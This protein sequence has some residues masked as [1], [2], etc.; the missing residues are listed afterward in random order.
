[1]RLMRKRPW[2]QVT[3]ACDQ[4]SPCPSHTARRKIPPSGSFLTYGMGGPRGEVHDIRKSIPK[5]MGKTKLTYVKNSL[6]N[7]YNHPKVRVNM[8]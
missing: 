4:F 6:G 7:P 5:S 3:K 1:M 2:K 8:F